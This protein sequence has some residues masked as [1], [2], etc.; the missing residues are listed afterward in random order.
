MDTYPQVVAAYFGLELPDDNDD[1]ERRNIV[2]S[3]IQELKMV[4]N[5][6]LDVR[7]REGILR[8][9]V[10]LFGVNMEQQVY[11][12]Q[13][14]LDW[15]AQEVCVVYKEAILMSALMHIV[16][17][18]PSIRSIEVELAIE[19]PELYAA[20]FDRCLG[21]LDEDEVDADVHE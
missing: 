3:I 4:F 7:E 13:A 2:W 18:V 19:I 6:L 1:R 10:R 17:L 21:L 8:N 16:D 15:A 9:M 14:D 5:I 20:M 12:V 11:D